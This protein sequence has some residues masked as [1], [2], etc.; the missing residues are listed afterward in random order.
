MPELALCLQPPIRDSKIP[1]L[2]WA[3]HILAKVHK[4]RVIAAVARRS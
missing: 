3:F 1:I 2:C 4:Q